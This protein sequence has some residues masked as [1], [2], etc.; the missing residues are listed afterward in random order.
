MDL[1]T[2]ITVDRVVFFCGGCLVFRNRGHAMPCN[3]EDVGGRVNIDVHAELL[4]DPISAGATRA[5]RSNRAERSL[6]WYQSCKERV[7]GSSAVGPSAQLRL[8]FQV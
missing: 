5:F 7:R 6:I 4:V 2:R 3:H 8:N 1:W